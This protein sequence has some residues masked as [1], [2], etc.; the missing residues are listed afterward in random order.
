MFRG[1]CDACEIGEKVQ[2]HGKRRKSPILMNLMD[3]IY[4]RL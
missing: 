4:D 3:R 2:G 1:V